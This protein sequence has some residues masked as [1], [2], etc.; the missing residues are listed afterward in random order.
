MTVMEKTKDG[1]DLQVEVLVKMLGITTPALKDQ[2]SNL[3]RDALS[4]NPDSIITNGSFF[5]RLRKL[6]FKPVPRKF[7]SNI[8]RDTPSSAPVTPPIARGVAPVPVTHAARGTRAITAYH[9][10]PF[11][12]GKYVPKK[13]DEDFQESEDA[14]LPASPYREDIVVPAPYGCYNSRGQRYD[15]DGDLVRDERVYMCEYA[16][17]SYS[18]GTPHITDTYDLY[19]L[20]QSVE[21]PL[22]PEAIQ[23]LLSTGV[24]A[25]HTDLQPHRQPAKCSLEDPPILTS[26][27]D[28]VVTRDANGY[29]TD[30][31]CTPTFPSTTAAVSI[32]RNLIAHYIRTISLPPSIQEEF[33]TAKQIRKSRIDRG[34]QEKARIRQLKVFLTALNC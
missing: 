34:K 16:L 9:Y 27:C 2:A 33:L 21:L 18:N 12:N 26:A 31:E 20:I 1:F 8:I 30:Q 5:G 15:E 24:Y 25:P 17:S 4:S 6:L 23:Q 7:K 32:K 3:L 29:G 19:A 14:Q 22:V 13:Y 11:I 28:P 10:D